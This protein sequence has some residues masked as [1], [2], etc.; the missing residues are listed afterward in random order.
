MVHSYV[1]IVHEV[2]N[3]LQICQQESCFRSS[4]LHSHMLLL[5]AI[6]VLFSFTRDV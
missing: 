3:F 1:M 2:V 5:R 4:L 6:S